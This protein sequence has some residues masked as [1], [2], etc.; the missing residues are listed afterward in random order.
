MFGVI[1]WFIRLFFFIGL[2]WF[3]IK[4][5]VEMFKLKKNKNKKKIMKIVISFA[6]IVFLSV[7]SFINVK[8][9]PN[10]NSE[11]IEEVF[12]LA[13]FEDGYYA[14]STKKFEGQITFGTGDPFENYIYIGDND[15][16]GKCGNVNYV[17]SPVET[18]RNYDQLYMLALPRISNSDCL[19]Y[20]GERY[21]FIDYNC[22]SYG[23][24]NILYFMI[25]PD[26]I[27][28]PKFDLADVIAGTD[29]ESRLE[30]VPPIPEEWVTAENRD[31]LLEEW[32]NDERWKNY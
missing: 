31:E 20:D 13:D 2:I 23:I 22:R 1:C 12:E 16:T 28:R 10:F 3:T 30:R 26:I 15:I 6:L 8:L 9:K 32:L 29:T 11:N 4:N 24:M 5:I 19:F 7:L 14:F 21:I 18:T 17:F 25:S 27:C